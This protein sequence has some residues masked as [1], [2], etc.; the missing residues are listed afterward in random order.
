M[1]IKLFA[2]PALTAAFFTAAAVF[3]HDAPGG[4]AAQK[5]DSS[6]YT[7]VSHDTLWG[8]SKKFLKDPLKWRKLWI[9]NPYIKNPD[10]IYPG[11]TVKIF[12]DGTIEIVKGPPAEQPGPPKGLPTIVLEQPEDKVIVLQNTA[13]PAIEA[14]KAPEKTVERMAPNMARDAVPRKGFIAQGEFDAAGVIIEPLEKEDR[15]YVTKGEKVLLSLKDGQSAK[16]GDRY[17]I[18]LEGKKIFH[19]VTNAYVGNATDNLGILTVTD[20]A[21]G[22]AEV[23][24]IDASYKEIPLGA[25]LTPLTKIPKEVVITNPGSEIKGFIIAAVDDRKE[26]S[27]G[28]MVY[29]DK[30]REDG[31]AT[32]NVFKVYRDRNRINDPM[33]DKGTLGIPPMDLGSLMVL[34]A[35]EKTSSCVILNS[36][37]LI[38][39]GD[40]VMAKPSAKEVSAK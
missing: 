38:N 36:L 4:E 18:F 30:G 5:G 6:S 14:K 21:A 28:N 16:T 9:Q 32:G 19:P 7:I 13:S 3:P 35:A 24:V 8:I 25:K 1:K 26:L 10:L 40:S 20:T 31:V 15:L 22:R 2:I 37:K 39:V 33:R 34:D 11:N 23:G 17:A 12:P 27:E 29:I